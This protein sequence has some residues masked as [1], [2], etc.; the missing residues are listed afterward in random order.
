[1][2]NK[3]YI[4]GA[5]ILVIIIAA[6]FLHSQ[7]SPS[8][9]Q[10]DD[11][12]HRGIAGDPIDIVGDFYS[13]WL[14]RKR[15]TNT[16]SSTYNPLESEVLSYGMQ[17]KLENFDFSSPVSELDPVLCQTSL[18]EGLRSRTIFSTE[19]SL[20]VMMLSSDRQAGGQAI[21][22]LEE[23]NDL[24]E[25]AD[26]TCGHGEEAPDMGEFTF[27]NNGYLLKDSLPDNFDKS[28]WHLVY[29]ENGVNGHTV[30]LLFGD[31][32]TCT[33]EAGNESSCQT[34]DFEEAMHIHAQGDMTEAGLDVKKF[35]VIQ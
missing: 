1:M 34:G 29:E 6:F 4:V 15:T 27:D 21:V 9:T 3:K 16:S 18:P 17:A 8:N 20:Q 31:S 23:H 25:I 5:G 33:D 26:I 2:N 35:E 13:S 19:N 30:P 14:A 22:T 32:S 10:V 7:N 28:N 24:W 11:T 12:K